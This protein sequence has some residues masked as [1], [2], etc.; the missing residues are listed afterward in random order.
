[1]TP[2]YIQLQSN[3][4]KPAGTII[5]VSGGRAGQADSGLSGYNISKLAQQ[6][7]NEHLQLG[8]SSACLSS[9]SSLENLLIPLQSTQPSASS[10]LCQALLPRE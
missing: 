4:K 3:H 1:M 9:R 10:R 2:H 6:R 7:R 8:K 5:K